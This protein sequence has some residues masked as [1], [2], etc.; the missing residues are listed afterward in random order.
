MRFFCVSFH[1][2]VEA[3]RIVIKVYPFVFFYI[4]KD[5]LKSSFNYSLIVGSQVARSAT[6]ALFTDVIAG[7]VYISSVKSENVVL[8]E[9]VRSLASE[10]I[11]KHEREAV[12]GIGKI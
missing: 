3:L 2:S 7:K 5:S 9:Y 1:R 10:H 4:C 12:Y 11:L 8:A 6:V